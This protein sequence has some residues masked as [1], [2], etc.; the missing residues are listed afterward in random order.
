MNR[1]IST[2]IIVAAAWLLASCGADK[3]LKKGDQY[4]AIGEYYEASLEYAK[5]YSKTPPK[6]QENRGP[7]AYKIG[8]SNR[9]MGYTAKALTGY[10]NAARYKYTD[11]LTYLYIGQ[12]ALRQRDYKSAKTA[13]EQYLE[14]HPGDPAALTGIQSCAAAPAWRKQGSEYTVREDR[15]F[16][17]NYADFSPWLIGNDQ[18]VYSSTRKTAT[19]DEASGI[20]G[21]KNGDLFYAKKDD[22]GKWQRPEPLPDAVN[23]AYDEGAGTVSPDGK[24]L[25]FT[26]CTWDAQ[27]PRMAQIYQSARSDASWGKATPCEIV[28]DTLSNYAH[29]AVSPDGKYLYFVSDMPGGM[30]GT[31]IWRCTLSGDH[32]FGPVENLGTPINTAG[33]ERFPTFR[34]N[35][36]LYYSSDGMVGMGGLDLFRARLDTLTNK[37]DIWHLPY[38]MNSE[39]DDFGMTFDGEFNRGYFSSNRANQK[40]W[41]KIYT[42]EHPEI[43]RTMTGWVYEQDGYELP[44]AVVYIVGDDGTNK[45]IGLKLDGSFQEE[46]Q[47]GV[48]YLLLA[49]CDGYLNVQQTLYVPPTEGSIDTTLQ[50]PLPSMNIPVLVRN[51]FYDF[52]KATILPSSYPALEKL[53]DLLRKNPSIVIELSSHCDYRGTAEYN[54]KLSQRRAESVVNYLTTHGIQKER[55]VARGYGKKRPKVITKKFAEM[56]PFLHAGDTLTEAYIRKLTKT[57]QDSCNGLNRRTEFSVLSTKFGLFDAQGN[58]KPDALQNKPD[59]T[60]AKKASAKPADTDKKQAAGTNKKPTATTATANPAKKPAADNTKKTSAATT[61]KKPTE[62]AKRQ[63]TDSIKATADKHTAQTNKNKPAATPARKDSTGKRR[64]TMPGKQ[65]APKDSAATPTNKSNATTAGTKNKGGKGTDSTVL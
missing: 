20:T 30:G 56:Y 50:F 46:I 36:D 54:E 12:L 26:R 35:G 1:F 65:S 19:G 32:G 33:N 61:N 22:K 39:G 5:A 63:A 3:H 51:V 43:V 28:K 31:D 34:P 6:K 60:Q 38:P 29:P 57:Q 58:L 40:G 21:T 14:Q 53:T 52:D 17:A 13:F 45:K 9:L 62:T 23:T 24:T 44:K 41:D 4:M 2:C 47:A 48:R 59:T 55:V 37:W 25:Y 49:T 11:T 27:Y 42:F 64:I 7:I 10:R 16:N 8:E 18:I 15:Q